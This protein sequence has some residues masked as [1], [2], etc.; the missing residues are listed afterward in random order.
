MELKMDIQLPRYETQ[1]G[2]YLFS[3]VWNS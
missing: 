3:K 1:N 2:H